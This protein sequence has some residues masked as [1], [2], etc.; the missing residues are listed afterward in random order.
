MEMFKTPN[1]KT[2]YIISCS[3]NQMTDLNVY[4]YYKT[5]IA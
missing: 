2:E 1:A 4:D 5:S 3:T